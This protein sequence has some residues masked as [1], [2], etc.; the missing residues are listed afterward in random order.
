MQRAAVDSDQ[1]VTSPFHYRSLVRAILTL[2]L[3]LEVMWTRSLSKHVLPIATTCISFHNHISR[4]NRLF[5]TILACFPAS[6][7]VPMGRPYPNGSHSAQTIRGNGG[8]N[9]LNMSMGNGM[10]DVDRYVN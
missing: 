4:S 9:S 1:E 7:F 3:H 8:K 6:N 10:K 2:L 5:P